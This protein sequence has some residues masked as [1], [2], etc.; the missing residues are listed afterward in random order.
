MSAVAGLFH[1]Q[2]ADYDI[3]NMKIRYASCSEYTMLEYVTGII[4]YCSSSHLAANADRCNGCSEGDLERRTFMN[5]RT[6]RTLKSRALDPKT[7]AE[8][9]AILLVILRYCPD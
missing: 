5:R 9:D 4:T 3:R 1:A 2:Q 7:W 8:N 6:E